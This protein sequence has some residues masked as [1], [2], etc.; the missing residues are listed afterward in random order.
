MIS[1]L[2]VALLALLLVAGSLPALSQVLGPNGVIAATAPVAGVSG[3]IAPSGGS[4]P[5]GKT[6]STTFKNAAVTLS[7]GNLTA[8]ATGGNFIGGASDTAIIASTEKRYW[9][10]VINQLDSS[11][12]TAAGIVNT[13]F[14]FSDNNYLGVSGSSLGYYPAN[15]QVLLSGG[16]LATIQTGA[17]GH[18]ICVAF[19]KDNAAIW[20]RIDN[21]NWNNSGAAN[22]ATNTGGLAVGSNLTGA[23]T[24]VAAYG[25]LNL[26]NAGSITGNLGGSA[27]SF[28]PPASFSSGF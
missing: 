15:G 5:A 17:V 11:G 23:N 21:G 13:G 6:W 7:N 1:R 28:T 8:T 12:G 2:R 9:E 27:F 16:A 4:P 10:V 22:P 26:T 24:I 3:V 18:V 20:F 19:D 25:V 14:I